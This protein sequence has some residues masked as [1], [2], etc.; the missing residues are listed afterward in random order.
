M[1]I[2]YPEEFWKQFRKL[3]PDT[4]RLYRRQEARFRNNWRDPRLHIRK[5][6]DH[7]YPFSFRIT[8]N[9]RVLFTFIETGTVLFATIG[10]RRESYRR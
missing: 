5:L 8:R 2:I 6:I 3:P 10:H 7:P 1:K 4:Q 9:Y